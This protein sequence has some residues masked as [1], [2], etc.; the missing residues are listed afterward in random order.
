MHPTNKN[1]HFGLIRQKLHM[2]LII[3]FS[4]SHRSTEMSLL[5]LSPSTLLSFAQPRRWRRPVRNPLVAT[6][7]R[8]SFFSPLS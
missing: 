3:V 8:V 1:C 7:D 2:T 6:W 4:S 5:V